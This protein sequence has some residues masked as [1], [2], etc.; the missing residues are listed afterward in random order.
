MM[1]LAVLKVLDL[2]PICMESN[3]CPS[4]VHDHKIIVSIQCQNESFGA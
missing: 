4:M 3:D 1:L 2:L